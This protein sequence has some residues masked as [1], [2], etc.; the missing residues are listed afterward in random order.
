[1]I[2]RGVAVVAATAIVTLLAACH[3]EDNWRPEAPFAPSLRPAFGAR[4]TDGKLH[5]WTGSPCVGVTRL[6][7]T[8]E[9]DRAE[10]V[11]TAPTERPATVEHLTL[12]GPYPGL[13][14]SQPLPAGFD[15]RKAESLR[16]SVYGGIDGWGSYTD[17]TE[18]VNGSSQHP[19]DTYLFQGVGWL[20]AA[21]VAV[22]D[23]ET[24]IAT[25]SPDPAKH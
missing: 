14:V 4:I 1:M 17:I 10:L 15:W 23:G 6:A 12:G 7:F 5:I 18:V 25:C 9:P 21:E 11:L 19:N 20:N 24:F 3:G 8:F 2:R 13:E 16:L 22:Q